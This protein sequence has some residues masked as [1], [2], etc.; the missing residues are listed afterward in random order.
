MDVERFAAELPLLFEDFP[1]SEH[2]KGRRFEDI[3][4]AVPN[5]AC[6]NNLA[7]VNLAA[8]LLPPGECYVEV[9]T[10]AGASLIAAERGN[11]G[12]EFVAVDDF[13]FAP[14]T[15]RGRKLP[16]ASRRALEDNLR[17]FGAD[18][19][20][21][22]LEGDA[23]EV[24]ETCTLSGRTVG[25]YYYDGPHAY[26]EQ[27]RGMRAIEPYLAD[28]ALVI[29]DDTDW[30]HVARATRDYLAA[31]PRARLL[32]EI[33]GADRGLPQWWEGVQAVAWER[34]PAYDADASPT[35]GAA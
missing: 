6:E 25:V 26:E 4:E 21:A 11:G 13:S 12:K 24:L 29:V 15:V 33:G 19:N 17:R 18:A 20:V 7:L 30:E 34:G 16:Q 2:P 14:L 8:S 5:L 28:R 31:Q 10:Y 35:L 23:F 9:G 1:R 27:L 22:I 32:L 3:L